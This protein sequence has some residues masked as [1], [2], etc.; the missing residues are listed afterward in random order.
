M[1]IGKFNNPQKDTWKY[2]IFVNQKLEIY[3]SYLHK[4]KK[5]KIPKSSP[6]P[7]LRINIVPRNVLN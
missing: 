2:V 4:T 3:G 7:L 1:Y 5:K 6:R